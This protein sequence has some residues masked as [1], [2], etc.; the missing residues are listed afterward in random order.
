VFL[1]IIRTDF[2]VFFLQTHRFNL[3]TFGK[4][5]HM[6]NFRISFGA[7]LGAILFAGQAFATPMAPSTWPAPYACTR[8]F[9]VSTTGS[10]AANCGS[11]GT[12]CGSLQNANDATSIGNTGTT[13]TGGDCV[14]VAAGTYN[15][16][17]T[18]Q[19]NRSGTNAAQNA[20]GLLTG[21]IAYIGAPNHASIINWTANPGGVGI[22]PTGNWI[23]LDGF[24]LNG[25]SL[26]GTS[27]YGQGASHHIWV[28][29]NLAHDSG[30]GGI[31]FGGG[32]DYFFAYH[33]E[34]YNTSWSAPNAQSGMGVYEPIGK[35]QTPLG[36][37]TYPAD[38]QPFHIQ[39]VGNV[40]HEN[41]CN[42]AAVGL[43]GGHD[44]GTHTDGNGLILDDFGSTQR[45]GSCTN[46]ACDYQ[47]GTLVMGNLAYHN[48]G[49]GLYA[50]GTRAPSPAFVFINNTGYDNCHDLGAGCGDIVN[51]FGMMN[52]T[53]ENNIAWTTFNGAGAFVLGNPNGAPV[54]GN[55]FK[56]NLTFDGTAGH[57]AYSVDS[58]FAFPGTTNPLVGTDPKLT[59]VGTGNQVTRDFHP[60][61]GSPVLGAG[62]AGPAGYTLTTPDG[63]T[64]PTPPNV[65]AFNLAG[66]SVEFHSDGR[67]LKN[68]NEFPGA[69]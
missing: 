27:I 8:N 3:N 4:G 25:N 5:I 20:Q 43:A 21:Y 2:G 64:Q 53:F 69:M 48:G 46:G 26:L 68:R 19:L 31:G 10:G 49:R 16:T 55:V 1:F 24:D 36:F 14:N 7:A 45:S 61:S 41:S 30:G 17:A 34:V 59:N 54:T 11:A 15:T 42:Q 35:D 6:M 29:N 44:C 50:G 28:L 51:L 52:S 22:N 32:G 38:T 9:F 62:T 12:P 57:N 60:L 37:N 13:L 56:N 65:G 63:N 39:F 66:G 58:S 40:M 47:F 67:E 33:N 23:A 18:I